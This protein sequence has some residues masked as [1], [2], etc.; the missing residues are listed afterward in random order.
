MSNN[1]TQPLGYQVP[2]EA[3]YQAY[4]KPIASNEWWQ[5]EQARLLA[6]AKWEPEQGPTLEE[7]DQRIKHDLERR[8]R[9]LQSK[10]QADFSTIEEKRA[11]LEKWGPI[12][13]QQYKEEEHPPALWR[14]YQEAKEA[15]EASIRKRLEED[16]KLL[17]P[18]QGPSLDEKLQ[19]VLDDQR[20]R[21]D[22]KQTGKDA[23]LEKKHDTQPLLI[24]D[25][26]QTEEQMAQAQKTWDELKKHPLVQTL[27][28]RYQEAQE[29]IHGPFAF[30]MNQNHNALRGCVTCGATWVGLMA[31]AASGLVWHPVGELMEE[32]DE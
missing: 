11:Y 6:A 22:E 28:Q 17:A 14:A 3:P 15:W 29:H 12:A 19:H 16:V 13:E 18:E 1:D 26:L 4:D 5:K 2:E 10:G 7:F 23:A 30:L 8:I 24:D 25:P 27:T 31:G 20:A 9:E 32:E 21:R